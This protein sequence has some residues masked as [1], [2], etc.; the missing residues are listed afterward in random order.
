[1]FIWHCGQ[2]CATKICPL[3]GRLYNY[4]LGSKPHPAPKGLLN[5]VGPTWLKFTSHCPM[6]VFL[7]LFW[8]D[9][10]Y[11]F[12]AQLHHRHLFP[13]WSLPCHHYKIQGTFHMIWSTPLF[14]CMTKWY[15]TN[16]F[17][18]YQ[19]TELSYMTIGQHHIS[20]YVASI[21]MCATSHWTHTQN[22]NNNKINYTKLWEKCR[23]SVH[24]ILSPKV[25]IDHLTIRQLIIAC[26]SHISGLGNHVE[27]ILM[28]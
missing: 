10:M 5:R 7:L 19:S 28:L 24:V 8:Y 6:L 11:P 22:N 18:S 12:W 15:I 23:W 1:M 14:W 13:R 20:L 16:S 21:D 3:W 26:R 27:E 2:W 17:K 25:K 9:Y 4:L